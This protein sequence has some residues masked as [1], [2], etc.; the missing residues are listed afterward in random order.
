MIAEQQA[1]NPNVVSNGPIYFLVGISSVGLTVSSIFLSS[2]GQELSLTLFFIVFT[3]LSTLIDIL[4]I[5]HYTEPILEHNRFFKLKPNSAQFAFVHSMTLL[6]FFY[7]S[8]VLIYKAIRPE[9]GINLLNFSI[10][11]WVIIILAYGIM[12]MEDFLASRQIH[13]YLLGIPF[14]SKRRLNLHI[15]GKKGFILARVSL[16]IS[17]ISSMFLLKTQKI[18]LPIMVFMIAVVF[19][20]FSIGKERTYFENACLTVIEEQK[21]NIP[22]EANPK[23]PD[24]DLPFLSALGL[25][26]D[27]LEDLSILQELDDEN[28]ISQPIIEPRENNS[29]FQY[30]STESATKSIQK[31]IE[32]V[33][34]EDQD[35][36]AKNVKTEN[37]TSYVYC[38]NCGTQNNKINEYCHAC[39]TSIQKLI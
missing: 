24:R 28:P 39:G 16:L 7:G 34:L 33:K 8:I 22:L 30:V 32:K 35:K 18:I 14:W 20:L 12:F 31:L 3:Y 11:V 19:Q 29:V 13:Q 38:I 6:T 26:D 10:P 27:T 21:K 36:I 2:L 15:E 9:L 23:D 1:N 5:S 17:L 37:E 4:K 25:Q